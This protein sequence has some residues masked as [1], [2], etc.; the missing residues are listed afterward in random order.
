M[1]LARI[2]VVDD[3]ASIRELLE[4]VLTAHRFQV[5]SA[6]D[7]EAAIQL[8]QA[9]PRGFDLVISDILMPGMSGFDVLREI[10]RINP[11]MAVFFLTTQVHFYA[12]AVQFGANDFIV[13]PFD[14]LSL[15]T[16]LREFLH[17]PAA[18]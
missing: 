16:K 3:E 2:L 6:S 15:E 7:G 14:Y 17:L 10:R 12:Q 1:A 5:V 4:V 8:I 9:N 11:E 18:A 13:K